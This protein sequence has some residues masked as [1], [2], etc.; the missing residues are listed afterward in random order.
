[1]R[2]SPGRWRM[3]SALAWCPRALLPTTGR[4][5]ALAPKPHTGA[6]PFMYA[7]VLDTLPSPGG[8]CGLAANMYFVHNG[9]WHVHMI[10]SLVPIAAYCQGA[11]SVLH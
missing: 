3:M 6:E 5:P 10:C 2:S 4:T 1:M 8:V 9:V 7:S 11:L